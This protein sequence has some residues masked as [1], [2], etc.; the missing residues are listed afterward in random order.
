MVLHLLFKH[1]FCPLFKRVSLFSDGYLFERQQLDTRGSP[2]L[3]DGSDV[4]WEGHRDQG[5]YWTVL[6]ELLANQ[7][8]YPDNAVITTSQSQESDTVPI[9]ISA[10]LL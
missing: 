2:N 10:K 6:G 7:A 8:N 9:Q 4:V 1:L 5:E 3:W